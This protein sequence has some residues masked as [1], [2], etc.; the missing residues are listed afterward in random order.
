[1][2]IRL[3]C[4][5]L[6]CIRL[7]CILSMCICVLTAAAIVAAT[8]P[9]F[10]TIPGADGPIAAN[11]P[12]DGGAAHAGQGRLPPY[13]LYQ[14]RCCWIGT[15]AMRSSSTGMRRGTGQQGTAQPMLS[16]SLLHHY[17]TA[18]ALSITSAP[19]TSVFLMCARCSCSRLFTSCSCSS[20]RWATL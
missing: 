14:C 16:A 15:R 5:R 9:L 1:M 20:S 4:I 13:S 12:V 11:G 7:M 2:C 18:N 6:L 10:P 19:S 3:M 17:C 8:A